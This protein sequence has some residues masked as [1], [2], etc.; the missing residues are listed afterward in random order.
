MSRK[1]NPW[2]TGLLATSGLA[3]VFFS[4]SLLWQDGHPQWA[5]L[6]TFV[7]AWSLIS[8]S[9]ANV[10]FA[11]RSGTI[12]ARIVDHNFAEMHERL[13]ELEREVAELRAT[14]EH[15]YRKAS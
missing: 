12:L 7:A 11:E 14:A 1:A 3:A 15:P 10:D 5:F 8:I 6:L 9:W 13:L 4:A 2:Q